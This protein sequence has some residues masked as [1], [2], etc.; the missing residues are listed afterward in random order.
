MPKSHKLQKNQH[1]L[2]VMA[3]D[4]KAPLTAIVDL[5]AVVEKGYVE[6]AEKSREL[7]SRARK[8]AAG[9]IQM[10]N[11]ILDYTLLSD[12][13]SV[14]KEFLDCAEIVNES[15]NTFKTIASR[16]GVH[17]CTLD[18]M[19]CPCYVYG[20]RTFLFRAF[21]NIIMNAIKY[22][23]EGGD[24]CISIIPLKEDKKVK[25][26]V[27]DT[28]IGIDKDDLLKVFQIFQRGKKARK[29]IDGSIG[30]GMSLVKQIIDG[31]EGS[32]DIQSEINQGTTV[33]VVLPLQGG[34][35]E[36]NFSG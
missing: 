6:D 8:K 5:L 36:N 14:K 29:N 16:R 21:N 23:R 22:N 24:I 12:K 26:I 34:V 33:T 7:V 31:H 15:I 11:D 18:E 28:G 9:L 27:K 13:D 19:H 3:H 17:F 10:V 25:I 30:L 1:P 2:T 4:I 35:N 32:I 20:N